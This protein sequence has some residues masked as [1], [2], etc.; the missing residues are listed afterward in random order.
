MYRELFELKA[1]VRYLER[2]SRVETTNAPAET[3]KQWPLDAAFASNVENGSTGT[4]DCG[5]LVRQ[6][7]ASAD[8]AAHHAPTPR[9]SGEIRGRNPL[10]PERPSYVTE[11][12]GR[13]RWLGHSST[14]AFTQRVL[15]IVQ[16]SPPSNPAP[17]ILLSSDGHTYRAET[18]LLTTQ[19]LP[20][21]S[22][23]PSKDTAAHYLDCVK[24]R[25]NPLLY[26]FDD[27]TFRPALQQF[28]R[29]PLNYAMSDMIWYTH[30]L[31]LLAM[32]K[33]LDRG[34]RHSDG[35]GSQISEYFMRALKVIPDMTFL[36]GQ[37]M[38][39]TELL[40]S[41]ALYLQSVDHRSAALIYVRL[42]PLR[43]QMTDTK[44]DI[45]SCTHGATVC[46][47]SRPRRN[48]SWHP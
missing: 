23:L 15:H 17:E 19:S 11:D 3:P 18:D 48:C 41:I 9:P 21:L 13:I 10:V 12:S 1:R 43:R 25:T 26:L 40:C 29:D 2:H 14:Y 44:T 38:K 32:G 4:L 46:T 6:G 30:F 34:K 42:F 36:C 47:E 7:Y 35:T 39:S 16:Q 37:H 20:D 45:S 24:F 8:L 5:Q 31:V 28:Y 33:S 27:E 22:N